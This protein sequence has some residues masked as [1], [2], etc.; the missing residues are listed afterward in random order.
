MSLT[1]GRTMPVIDTWPVQCQIYGYLAAV[2]HHWYQ[3]ILLD[4][5]SMYVKDWAKIVT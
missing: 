2:G 3:I 4:D 5:K 1:G